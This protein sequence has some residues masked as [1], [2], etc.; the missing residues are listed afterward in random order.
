[1]RILIKRGK[2]IE[3]PRRTYYGSYEFIA[4]DIDGRLIGIGLIEDK[5]ISFENSDLIENK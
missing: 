4:E 5:K 1:M 2:I 3:E